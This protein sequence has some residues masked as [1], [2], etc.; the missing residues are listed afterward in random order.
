MSKKKQRLYEPEFKAKVA[1]EALKEEKTIAQISS[2]YQMHP[3]NVINWKKDLLE[4][5][6]SVFNR[7]NQEK[8]YKQELL[9]R[10][11]ETEELYK[12]IGQLTTQV[13]W[14]KKKCRQ[15]GLPEQETSY[16]G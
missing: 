1:L 11:E 3:N 12:Q 16:R 15:A 7:S 9:K 8:A 13:N 2:D 4:N 14:L 5:A 6:G 10:E